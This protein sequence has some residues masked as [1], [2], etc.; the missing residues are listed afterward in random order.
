MPLTSHRLAAAFQAARDE[1]RAAFIAYLPAGYPDRDGFLRHARRLLEYADAL[2][3]GLP[4][5]DPLG[6]GPTIQKASEVAL[7]KGMT[8]RGTFEQAVAL[9]ES[10]DK[11]LLV[12]TYYNPILATGEERFV[13]M[14]VESGIDG[15]ILP[16]LPP[17]EADTIRPIA[18]RA[19][20]ALT[21]LI[22]PTSTPERIRLV[23]GACT[24]FLYAVSVTG[25]TGARESVLSEV[26]ELVRRAKDADR[27]LPVAVGF[28]VSDRRSAR[29]VAE[30]ADGVV[31]G[32]ALINAI[33]RGEDLAALASEILEGCRRA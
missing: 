31:V 1:N 25:V 30:H 8:V 13:N 18:E 21:F 16:D 14:A 33:G 23:T 4:Y 17:D 19:G 28:G 3:I 12:M 26:P 20:L 10:T 5:S 7:A 22:A 2:E 27:E 24:G 32:S 11:P 15:L 9:R 6:D 29:E